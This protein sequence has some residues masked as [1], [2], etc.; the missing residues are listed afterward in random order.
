METLYST[1]A[2]LF[3]RDARR[4]GCRDEDV[5]AREYNRQQE[6]REIGL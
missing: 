3:I 1:L 5:T 2:D 6:Q 4:D